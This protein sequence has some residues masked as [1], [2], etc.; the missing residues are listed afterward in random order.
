[1]AMRPRR[2]AGAILEHRSRALQTSFNKLMSD[3]GGSG[4]STGLANF[5]Q[6]FATDLKSA[7]SLGDLV[8]SQ[9]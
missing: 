4:S 2:P 8:N 6:A 5:L 7:A 9:A 1:M 3:L